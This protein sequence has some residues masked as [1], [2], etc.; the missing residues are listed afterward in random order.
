MR[1][2]LETLNTLRTLSGNEQMDY[3]ESHKDVP[4]LKEVLQYAYDPNKMYG[5]D[6]K[7]LS[8]IADN[9]IHQ[10]NLTFSQWHKITSILDRFAEQKAVTDE[11]VQEF[12]NSISG[13]TEDFVEMCTQVLLKDLRLGMSVKKFRKIWSDFCEYYPYMGAQSFKIEKLQKLVYPAYVQ[14]KMDGLYCNLIVDFDNKEVAYISRQ[15][16]PINI[17]GALDEILFTES[18]RG[19][20]VFNG[21]IL[22]WNTDKPY[23]REISNGIIKRDTHTEEELEAIRIVCWDLIPYENFCDGEWNVDYKYRYT[24]LQQFEKAIKNEKFTVVNTQIAESVEQA[25]TM[26]QEAYNNGEEGVVVK[27]FLQI[28]KDG[29]PSGQIKIKNE[30]ECELRMV[31]FYEGQGAYE[32]LCGS[33]KCVSEDGIVEV[34]VKPR[35]PQDARLI[36]FNQPNYLNKILS[37]KFNALIK[38]PTKDTYSL[39]LPVFTEV[40]DFDKNTANTFKEIEEIAK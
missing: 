37:V 23:P 5:V 11:D 7:K 22:V 38:S 13:I 19:K 2:V 35:T 8:R 1:T 9:G 12:K 6:K 14:T 16:K 18:C 40:R 15:G 17:K 32:G 27:N 36:W 21:E 31:E 33:I 39:Y 30:K 10:L 20:Y 24:L 3:L 28:W 34:N 26:F 4:L 25:L 29:K